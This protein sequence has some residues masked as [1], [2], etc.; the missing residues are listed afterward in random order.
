MKGNFVLLRAGQLRLVVPQD[1]MGVARYIDAGE[2]D[3]CFALS[4]TMKLLPHR[5]PGRFIAAEFNGEH[6]GAPWCWDEL[7]VLI[8]VE[9]HAIPVPRA[10]VSGNT[11]VKAYVEVDGE[12]AFLC[13]AASLCGYAL[14]EA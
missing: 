10:L 13:D 4:D 3:D 7:R 2:G 8:D 5:P 9:L 14:A 11:P 6:A 12:L 1:D